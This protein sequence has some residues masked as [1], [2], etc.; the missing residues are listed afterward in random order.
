M[1]IANFFSTHDHPNSQDSSAKRSTRSTTS[2]FIASCVLPLVLMSCQSLETRNSRNA[3]TATPRPNET[4]AYP[5]QPS[6]SPIV[7]V[8]PAPTPPPVP[9]VILPPP[10]KSL[11]KVGVIVGPGGMKTFAALGVFREMNRARIPIH[12][13]AGLEWGSLIGGL[14]AS[15]GQINDAEWKAYKLREDNLPEA[16]FL[17]S[18]VAAANVSKLGSFLDASFAGQAVDKA[19]IDFACATSSPGSDKTGWLNRGSMKSAMERC[20]PYPPM[21]Q[22]TASMASPFAIDEAV[23]WLRGRGANVILLID[24]LGQGEFIPLKSPTDL[25]AENLVW[26]EIRR[27]MYRARPPA[28][29]HVIHVNTSGHPVTDFD[30][31][32]AL[33]D[34]GQKAA[35]DVCNK[36]VSQYGF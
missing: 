20:L 16:G 17:Q 3:R 21:F 8:P 13:I 24:V 19:R 10:A 2:L 7:G 6:T 22:N 34:A 12:A 5:E 32:R 36:M 9:P 15:Q 29:N 23:T 4:P 35:T 31:R 28:I 18:K 25:S 30:G 26:A 1:A 14:Y 11:V 27:Q 33:M